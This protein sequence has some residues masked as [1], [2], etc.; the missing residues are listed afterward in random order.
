[1]ALRVHDRSARTTV[2]GHL[3]LKKMCAVVWCY[4]GPLKKAEQVFKPIRAFKKPALDLAGPIPHP[5]L[6]SMFDGLYP[7]GHQW[8]WKATSCAN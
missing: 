1:M 3:H 4:S 7:P 6:Q 8:Y 2:S 5:A